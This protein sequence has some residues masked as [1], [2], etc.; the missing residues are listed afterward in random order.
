[1]KR[2][3]ITFAAAGALA[4]GM[5][6]AQVSTPEPHKGAGTAHVTRRAM[7]RHRM[8]QALNLTDAQKQQSKVIFEQAKQSAQPVVQQLKQNRVALA[9]A[10]KAG[11]TAR[12]HQIT[13]A[14]GR[15]RGQMMAV[16]ADAM[17]KF[18]QTLTPEQRA[19][20]DQLRVRRSGARTKA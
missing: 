10:V 19:K 20:A 8:M 4:A 2:R 3:W 11:D 6:F 9:A 1:M 18:Y 17:A 13:A 5:V 7:A 16:R 12:I 15:L 14:Q